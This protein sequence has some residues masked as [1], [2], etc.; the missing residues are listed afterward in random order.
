MTES[1]QGNQGI[2][3]K[4]NV[5]SLFSGCG[6]MDLGFEGHFQVFAECVNLDIHPNWEEKATNNKILPPATGFQNVFANDILPYARA[7]WVRYFGKRGKNPNSF[8]LESII[9]LVKLYKKGE[10]TFPQNIEVITGGFPCQDF[11]VAGYRK[12]FDSHK[13]HMGTRLTEDDNP[14][15]ENRGRLYIWMREVIEIIKPKVFIAENVKG[16]VSLGDVKNVIEN[17]FC[18]IDKKGYIVVPAQILNSADFGVPQNRERIFF[19]GLNKKYLKREAIE[20]L[21]CENI[22][23]QYDP[24]PPK[25]HYDNRLNPMPLF[26]DKLKP[27]VTTGIALKGLKEPHIEKT[28]TDQMS[29]SKAR[30]YGKKQQGNI[31]IKLDDI[32]PTIRAEHHGNIEFRRLS[33]EHG[34][35]LLNETNMGLPERR[36][37]VRECARIQ[38]F[39]DDYQ[40]VKGDSEENLSNVSASAAYKLIGNAV[41]PLLAYHIARRLEDIWDRLFIE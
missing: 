37:T 5:L 20:A 17:D 25:T 36:L 14:A 31:E 38:T 4:K 10:F 22:T 41:P 27:Y 34:G 1:S 8:H 3:M 39:P 16:L 15:M 9:N 19:I 33:S 40:F 11:S 26:G 35:R 13:N 2:A 7:A 21:S 32:A 18:A 6:G 24:Y 23:D 30:Y 12:G 28:D 29:F